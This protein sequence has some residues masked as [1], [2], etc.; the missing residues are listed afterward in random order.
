MQLLRAWLAKGHPACSP[1][2]NVAIKSRRSAENKVKD[3]DW[4][5]KSRAVMIEAEDEAHGC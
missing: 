2:E 5:P 4:C 1:L 3:G